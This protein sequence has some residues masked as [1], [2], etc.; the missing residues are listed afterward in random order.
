MKVF[1]AGASGAIGTRLVPQL[2]EGGARGGRNLDVAG[3]RRAPPSARS[4]PGRA[5]PA[6]RARRAPSRRR[7]RA[8]GDRPPGDRAG[9][10]RF[11]RKLDKTLALTNRLRT[12]GTRRLLAAGRESGRDQIRRA[13][14]RQHAVH[15]RG[16]ACQDRGRPAPADLAAGHARG[17]RGD[18]LRRRDGPG[19]RRNR[20][21]VRLFYGAPNDGLLEPVRKRRWPIVGNGGGITSFVHLDDAAAATVL[22]LEHDGPAI[23][24]VAD[25]DPAPAREW[26]PVLASTLGAKP[27]RRV[28]SGSRSCSPARPRSYRDRVPR[29]LE[30]E[31]QARARLDTALSDLAPGLRRGVHGA[32]VHGTEPR[33]FQ[34][35]GGR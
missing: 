29:R 8:R 10:A 21:S 17:R 1:V 11:S 31:G 7:V 4:E 19:R 20:P 23:Y 26:L 6:R 25:D 24:N 33:R 32:A 18:A 34:G 14:L 28:R 9:Q 15:P 3:G 22:A 5:R 30:R 2:I 35:S 27:P 12:E 13:E 16:R